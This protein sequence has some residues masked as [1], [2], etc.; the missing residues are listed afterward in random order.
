MPLLSFSVSAGFSFSGFASSCFS[1]AGFA[2]GGFTAAVGLTSPRTA[3]AADP[4]FSFLKA[5]AAFTSLGFS[6]GTSGFIS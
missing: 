6:S 2:S 4:A 5:S 3:S 1:A